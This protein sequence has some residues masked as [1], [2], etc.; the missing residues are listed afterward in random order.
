MKALV[1]CREW[2]SKLYIFNSMSKYLHV[3]DGVMSTQF[4][5]GLNV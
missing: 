2:F 3:R 4:Q 5:L 1:I